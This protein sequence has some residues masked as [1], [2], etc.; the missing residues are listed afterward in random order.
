VETALRIFREDGYEKTTMRRIAH[1]AGLSVG[2]AYYYFDGKDAL[3][4]ELYRQIQIDHR[5]RALPLLRQG[6]SLATNLRT[7]LH[8][9]LDT[10]APYHS[11]GT[12]MLATA[13]SPTATVSPF[14]SASAEPRETAT[15]LMGYAVRTSSGMPTGALGERLPHLLW[16][17]YL[18]VT[19]H[20][21]TDTSAGQRRTRDLV[22]GLAPL[23]GKAVR[24]TRIPGGRALAADVVALLD[25]SLPPTSQ[26]PTP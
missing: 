26:E 17:A 9:G 4:Q 18:G 15:A 20:W 24:L 23:I 7:V 6:A 14:S 11:F 8:T 10:M 16:L 5:D 2:N 1:E 25:R 3:V 22:D 21:V 13:L 12:T 19:V